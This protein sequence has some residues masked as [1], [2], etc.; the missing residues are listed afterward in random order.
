MA[1]ITKGST[2]LRMLWS[3]LCDEVFIGE[4]EELDSSVVGSRD[5]PF[6]FGRAPVG[7]FL[8]RV[9]FLRLTR[10]L[11]IGKISAKKFLLLLLWRPER[12]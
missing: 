3:S 4:V 7:L 10:Y 2:G 12:E 9:I 6:C 5:V 1:Q 11:S 8:F